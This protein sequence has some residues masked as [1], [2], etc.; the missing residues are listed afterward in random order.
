MTTGFCF[1][2]DGTITSTEILP[3]IASDIGLA[4]EIAT[5]T[6]IT[7]DGLITFDESLRLRVALL[8]Q[9]PLSKIHKIVNEVILTPS[10]ENFIRTH[11]ANCFI[12]TG[13]LDIWTK[14]ITEKLGCRGFYSTACITNERV[15]L[16]SV[17]LKEM[18]VK[19]IRA[20]GFSK[21]IAIGD[22]ANDTSMLRAA[23]IGIAYGGIHSP[24]ACL[25]DEADYIVHEGE[26]LCKLLNALS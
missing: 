22:G 18:A 11:T 20:L 19:K 5:L 13:N 26:S 4:E 23:D 9:I 7:M 1:D 24:A 17:L 8:G 15:Y 2:L 16:K 12:I 6:R 3:C 10:I 14:Q 21:I 25:I